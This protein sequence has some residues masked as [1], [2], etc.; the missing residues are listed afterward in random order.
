MKNLVFFLCS[1]QMNQVSIYREKKIMN[2]GKKNLIFF[3]ISNEIIEFKLLRREKTRQPIRISQVS[4][5]IHKTAS[6]SSV[7]QLTR[8]CRRVCY[9]RQFWQTTFCHVSLCC[10]FK[11]CW[12]HSTPLS[13]TSFFPH[14][15]HSIEKVSS[16]E[17][18]FQH[19]HCTWSNINLVTF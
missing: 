6:L 17:S 11:Q 2:F 5:L 16:V 19:F 10:R 7:L 18:C 15:Q 14:L 1:N 12:I 9:T 8:F 3:L 13:S 4:S